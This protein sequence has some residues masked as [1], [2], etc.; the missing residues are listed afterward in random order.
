MT[1]RATARLT[2]ID[3]EARARELDDGD[4]GA[5]FWQEAADFRREARRARG[6]EEALEAALR[7]I[8]NIPNQMDGGDWTEIEDARC[9]AAAALAGKP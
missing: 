6:R 7:K 8:A 2:D 5:D 1:G 4:A 9:I 3:F